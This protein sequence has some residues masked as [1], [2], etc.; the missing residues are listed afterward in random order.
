MG[1][2]I[3]A[4]IAIW[5]GLGWAGL[6]WAERGWAGLGW[7]HLVNSDKLKWVSR[8]IINWSAVSSTATLLPV[9]CRVLVL[10]RSREMYLLLHSSPAAPSARPRLVTPL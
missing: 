10:A 3:G 7:R 4:V 9:E 6:G 8:A 1:S 2:V 5:A